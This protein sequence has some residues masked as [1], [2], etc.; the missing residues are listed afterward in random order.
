MV[1]QEWLRQ[2]GAPD[3]FV[4][5]VEAPILEHEFGGSPVGDVAQA[6]DSLSFLEIC[7]PRIVDWIEDG[8]CDLAKGQTKLDFMYERIRHPRARDVARPYYERD[9][10]ELA[11]AFPA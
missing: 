11:A 7:L 3:S 1:V 8:D 2:N 5:G 4:V 6:A 10:A 9:S